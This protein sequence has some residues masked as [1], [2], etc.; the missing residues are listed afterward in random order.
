MCIRDS[1]YL[2][3]DQSAFI[4]AEIQA[5]IIEVATHKHGCCVL[6]R[7]MDRAD[8]IRR[9]SLVAAV[10]DCTIQLVQDQYGNYVVQYVLD[11]D[12]VDL[13]AEKERISGLLKPHLVNLSR[14]KFSSNVV[15]KLLRL[16]LAGF[17]SATAKA[18]A[19]PDTV[20]N[21]LCHSFANYVV[22]S[23]LGSVGESDRRQILAAIRLRASRIRKDDFGAKIFAKLC[24]SYP[25]LDDEKSSKQRGRNSMEASFGKFGGSGVKKVENMA[26]RTTKG[27]TIP[28]SES[29]SGGEN[30]G[31]PLGLNLGYFPPPSLSQTPSLAA[32]D[33]SQGEEHNNVV[34][35]A[36]CQGGRGRHS[37][38]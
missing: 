17:R 29:F 38:R 10:V 15:E 26:G 30:G 3:P 18:L 33:V 25:Y 5:R 22:Q 20:A 16:D 8:S 14:Q 36:D 1:L 37:E 13:K 31:Y 24:R 34:S 4:Y 21:L 32:E 7:A 27:Q 11:F 2:A 12:S 6:Q 9:R 35:G 23:C 28:F 19:E